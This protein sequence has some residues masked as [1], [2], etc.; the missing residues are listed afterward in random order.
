MAG[1][2]LPILGWLGFGTIWM[3]IALFV[4]GII[5]PIVYKVL[6]ALGVGFVTFVGIGALLSGIEAYVRSL[7][8]QVPDKIF[9]ILGMA[10]VDIAI[11][12][13][14]AALSARL[15]IM[16]MDKLMNRPIRK[17]GWKAF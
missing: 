1:P 3:R 14:F 5:L 16:M 4:F 12:I 17:M 13:M 7:F 15:A 2:L 6:A 10:Q 9:T 8:S 11:N